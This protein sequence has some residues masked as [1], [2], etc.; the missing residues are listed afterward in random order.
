MPVWVS[1]RSRRSRTRTRLGTAEWQAVIDD[2]S[3]FMDLDHVTAARRPSTAL[4]IRYGRAAARSQPGT[5]GDRM[6][7]IYKLENED[8]T[9]ADPPTFRSSPGTSWNA[10]DTIP[11]GSNELSEFRQAP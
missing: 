1:F 9:P 6:A 11:L 7:F 10:G 4:S 5:E 2:A 8:G 3:E